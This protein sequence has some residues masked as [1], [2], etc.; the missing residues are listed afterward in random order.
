MVGCLT[1][2]HAAVFKG[3]GDCSLTGECL[4]ERLGIRWILG[5]EVKLLRYGNLD[6]SRVKQFLS[7][8][9][10]GQVTAG[11]FQKV[12]GVERGQYTRLQTS[13]S[14][15]SAV[16]AVASAGRSASSTSRA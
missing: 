14:D 13:T 12:G 7:A 11:R 5:A 15:Q 10:K 2:G 4:P 1:V 3:Q 16:T 6:T 8:S 9:P